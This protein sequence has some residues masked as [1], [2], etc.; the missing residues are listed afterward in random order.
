MSL[1]IN[2]FN[3]DRDLD[4]EEAAAEYLASIIEEGGADLL[5]AALRDI[6]KERGMTDIAEA[7]GM[8]REM[9]HQVLRVDA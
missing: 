5:A 8:T 6:T 2:T 7:K 4:S 1:K 3:P 9:L